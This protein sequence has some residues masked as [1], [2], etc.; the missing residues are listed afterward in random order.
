MSKTFTITTQVAILVLHFC[1]MLYFKIDR[2]KEIEQTNKDVEIVN[3]LMSE[4]NTELKEYNDKI[5]S[6]LT[7][8][9]TIIN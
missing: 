8:P 9:E 2:N 6:L 4:V 5:D 3:S 1:I 7:N